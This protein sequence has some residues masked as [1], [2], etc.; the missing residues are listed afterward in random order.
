[1]FTNTQMATLRTTVYGMFY[2][3]KR[4]NLSAISR[5]TNTSYE[6]L[7]YFFSDS[8]WSIDTLNDV[9]LNILQNQPTTRATLTASSLLTIPDALNP[10]PKKP[11]ALNTSIV[12][13]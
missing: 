8:D 5:K 9:R 2:D 11:K 3:Y 4:L 1:M 12:A 13:L 7:Q 10:M 6:K